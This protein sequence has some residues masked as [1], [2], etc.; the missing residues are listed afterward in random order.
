[1]KIGFASLVGAVAVT[2]TG[3]A[4][5]QSASTPRLQV[6]DRSPLIVH[7]TGFGARERVAVTVTTD[8][9]RMRYGVIATLR[10]TFTARFDEI[11]LD[12]CTGATLVAAGRRSEVVTLKIGLRECPGPALDPYP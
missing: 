12:A 7:G 3:V 1:M 5:A 6:V 10:G 8:G 9:D 2:L 11:R 4:T